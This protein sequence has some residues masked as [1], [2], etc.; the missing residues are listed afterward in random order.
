M[1]KIKSP[2]S[3][4]E[5]EKFCLQ[6]KIEDRKE[7]F[8]VELSPSEAVSLVE[9]INSA[10]EENGQI[11]EINIVQIKNGVIEIYCFLY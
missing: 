10:R 11:G 2:S 3:I 7:E 4:E 6:M 1:N 5:I 9:K 8:S